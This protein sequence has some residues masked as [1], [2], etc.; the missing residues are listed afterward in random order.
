MEPPPTDRDSASAASHSDGPA[1]APSVETFRAACEAHLELVW[2]FAAYCGVP[3][4][5]IEPVVHKVFGVIHGRLISLERADELRVA[6]VGTA[7][8]VVR[9]YLRQLGDHSPLEGP[10]VDARPLDFGSVP[11][12]ESH[13]ACE[14][15]D[16][17]LARMTET[18]REVFI[19]C[20]IE[21][22][23]LFETAE[24]LHIGESTLRIRLEDARKIFNVGSAELRA[25][26]FW[27]SRQAPPR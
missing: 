26:Q 1:S 23:S 5:A 22:F 8:Q 27:T 13:R 24:A 19:L 4:H 14:L 6:I 3:A 10:P 17:I 15:C 9:A 16:L 21:G 20:E 11:D 18:E 25:H 2:R 7:R 12:L